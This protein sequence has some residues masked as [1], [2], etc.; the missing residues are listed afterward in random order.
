MNDREQD[1]MGQQIGA[2]VEQDGGVRWLVLLLG[3]V[4]RVFL[5]LASARYPEVRG[6][7]TCPNCGWRA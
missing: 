1:R 4:A 7:V 5:S 6:K 2:A 3:E